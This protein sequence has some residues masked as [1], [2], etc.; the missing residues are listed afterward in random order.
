MRYFSNTTSFIQ[1]QVTGEIPKDRFTWLSDL[2][3]SHAF[4]SI[5]DS[6][7]ELSAGWT[8]ADDFDNP[9]FDAP[10]SLLRD[11][12]ALFALRVD[13]RRVP[14]S[15][16]K[17]HIAREEKKFLAEHPNLR[18]APKNKREEIK[19]QVKIKLLANTQAIPTL[20]DVSWDLDSGVLTL[21]SA[22]TSAIDRFEGLFH[23]TF[24]GLSLVIIHP[25]SRAKRLVTGQLLEKLE[26]ANQA[27]SDAV[28][29]VI[30]DNCWIGN[31]F[32]L[33]LLYRG[34]NDGA[35]YKICAQG[36]SA[37]G[38][39]FV[40]W[41]DE[42]VVLEGGGEEGGI[43]RVSVSGSQ[44][45]YKEVQSA[46]A[47][48]KRIT[49]ATICMDKNENSWK[50]TLEGE[51][52]AFKSFRA[53]KV[54]IEKDTTVDEMSELEAVFFEKMYLLEAGLQ[55]FDSL[56]LAFLQTRLDETWGAQLQAVQQWLENGS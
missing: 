28:A 40:T 12:Y 45:C 48:N 53:P 29:A 47:Q 21:F 7:E 13:Q 54:R 44:D 17:T 46:L 42:R 52:F 20:V 55:Q 35:D 38:E 2:L 34:L 56:L 4:Q 51:R 14:A 27:T 8:R 16:L 19:E 49:S 10:I 36:Q 31:D 39:P 11:H 9:I 1:M 26:A 18:R 5:E 23:K 24:E 6:T 25:Y 41:I 22:T 33:W 30:R 37:A 43:Q 50:L 32:M 3:A 15:V